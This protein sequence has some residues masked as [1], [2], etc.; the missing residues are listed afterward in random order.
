MGKR[1]KW[2][3]DRLRIRKLAVSSAPEGGDWAEFGV[4]G[5]GTAGWFEKEIP[6]GR[7]L[8]L[9]DSFEGLPMDGPQASWKKGMFASAVYK[10][11]TNNAVVIVGLFEDTL[12]GYF[13]DNCL[14][15][16]HVDCDLYESTATVLE[17]TADALMPG[18]IILFDEMYAYPGWEEGE[19]KALMEWDREYEW[20]HNKK[21]RNQAIIRVL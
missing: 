2:E 19:Y 21:Q 8:H 17:H 7:T 20:V 9:F 16:I 10:P 12:P 18:A 1:K 14:S 4:A 11:K 5:G 15:F 6:N 13:T 3:M